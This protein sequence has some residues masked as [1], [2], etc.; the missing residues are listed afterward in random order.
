MHSHLIDRQVW[1]RFEEIHQ[2]I[3]EMYPDLVVLTSSSL[4]WRSGGQ[5]ELNADLFP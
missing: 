2:E 5:K 3:N 4:V 1:I